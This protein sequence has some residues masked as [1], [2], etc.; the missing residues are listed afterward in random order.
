MVA[1][2]VG[3]VSAFYTVLRQLAFRVGCSDEAV[4]HLLATLRRPPASLDRLRTRL[5]DRPALEAAGVSPHVTGVIAEGSTGTWFGT[6]GLRE[7]AATRRGTR[8]G[9]PFGDL[10][11]NFV[12]GEIFTGVAERMETEGLVSPL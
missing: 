2:F 1:V 7:V 5:E 11:F 4:A 8:P 9:D 12:A 3:V 10:V 6:E